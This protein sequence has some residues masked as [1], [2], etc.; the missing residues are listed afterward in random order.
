MQKPTPGKNCTLS[1]RMPPNWCGCSTPS[2]YWFPRGFQVLVV[3]PVPQ[4]PPLPHRLLITSH[5]SHPCNA[6]LRKIRMEDFIICAASLVANT[7]EAHPLTTSCPVYCLGCCPRCPRYHRSLQAVPFLAVH[8][9][10]PGTQNR[11]CYHLLSILSSEY[12]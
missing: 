1:R 7:L 9:G 8:Y 4:I 6:A 5:P 2:N 12:S 10:K 3:A 11:G